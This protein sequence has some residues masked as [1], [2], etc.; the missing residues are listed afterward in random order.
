M[1]AEIIYKIIV[2]IILLNLCN[3]IYFRFGGHGWSREGYK[4][5]CFLSLFTNIVNLLTGATIFIVLLVLY[6]SEW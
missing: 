5:N 1:K 2:L 4:S 3:E 6:F